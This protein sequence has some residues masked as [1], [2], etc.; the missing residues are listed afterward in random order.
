MVRFF[1]TGTPKLDNEIFVEAYV[2]GQFLLHK[3]KDIYDLRKG[4]NTKKKKK[5]GV[6]WYELE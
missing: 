5:N 6:V 2:F 3:I 4:E 1:F